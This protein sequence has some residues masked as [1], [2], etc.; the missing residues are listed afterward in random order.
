MEATK[1]TTVMKA[2]AAELVEPAREG[3]IFP[4]SPFVTADGYTIEV[5][6]DSGYVYLTGPD[7]ADLGRYVTMTE[8][9]EAAAQ[10]DPA[11]VMGRRNAE[12]AERGELAM[13][14]F[15]GHSEGKLSDLLTDL[16][17]Y[18]QREGDN[19]DTCT[20]IAAQRFANHLPK[21]G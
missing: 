16:Y 21:K 14:A 7:E 9:L 1:F 4:A 17:A 11:Y 20:Q 8:A 3:A 6:P 19:W 15:F 2:T 12:R 18:A 5:S 13:R 10:N